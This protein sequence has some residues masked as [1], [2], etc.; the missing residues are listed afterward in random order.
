MTTH[1]EDKSPE[2]QTVERLS[3]LQEKN[4]SLL[5]AIKCL[6]YVRLTCYVFPWGTIREMFCLWNFNKY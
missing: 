1:F 4:Q 6:K 5:T 3:F 2:K